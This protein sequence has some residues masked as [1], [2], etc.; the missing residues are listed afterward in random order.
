VKV[1]EQPNHEDDIMTTTTTEPTKRYQAARLAE[2]VTGEELRD[3]LLA[4]RSVAIFQRNK[5]RHLA[6]TDAVFVNDEGSVTVLYTHCSPRTGRTVEDLVFVSQAKAARD[7]DPVFYFYN[8][9]RTVR[10][11]A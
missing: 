4:D 7:A 10:L 9:G 5:A 11:A 3:L 8:S 6:H 2:A 1:T